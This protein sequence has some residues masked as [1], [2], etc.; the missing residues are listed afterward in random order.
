MAKKEILNNGVTVV[1][2]VDNR[3]KSA[4]VVVC[5]KGG[6]VDE[7][8]EKLGVTHLLEHLLFKRTNKHDRFGIAA[9]LD[10]LGGEVNAVTDLD[11]ICIYGFV[12]AELSYELADFIFE[13]IAEAQFSQSDLQLEKEIIKQEILESFDDP[14]DLLTQEFYRGSFPGSNLAS[15]VFGTVETVDAITLEDCRQRRSQLWCGSRIFVTAIGGIDEPRFMELLHSRLGGLPAGEPFQRPKVLPFFEQRSAEYRFNQ[16]YMLTARGWPG[17]GSDDYLLGHLTSILL[18]GSN[19]SRLFQRLREERGLVYDIST[20]VESIFNVG[21]LIATAVTERTKGKDVVELVSYV[22]AELLHQGVTESEFHRAQSMLRS[23]LEMEQD[24][25]SSRLWR[26][27]E[28][29][30]L[31]GRNVPTS[32]IAERLKNMTLDEV[33]NFCRRQ[34]ANS[35][36]TIIILGDVAGV[37]L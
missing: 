28:S 5:L 4:G 16:L 29:E 37:T 7:A 25:L 24:S 9:K 15:P 21:M 14:G 32:E 36:G 33:N 22:T 2:E 35:Q 6:L 8:P 26:L 23:V 12:P 34:T 18:G 19:T 1:T 17:V 3:F 20:S 27:V 13:L 30:V 10:E 11:T 31:L